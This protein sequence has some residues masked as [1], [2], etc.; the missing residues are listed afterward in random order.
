MQG[1]AH[2]LES[3]TGFRISGKVLSQAAGGL[4]SSLVFALSDSPGLRLSGVLHNLKWLGHKSRNV[5][6]FEIG[7][8]VLSTKGQQPDLK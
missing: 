7:F 6:H 8:I 5:S 1:V 3:A 4:G 2:A